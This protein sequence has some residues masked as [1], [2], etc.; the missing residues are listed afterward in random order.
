MTEN[1]ECVPT[2]FEIPQPQSD[3]DKW[4]GSRIKKTEANNRNTKTMHRDESQNFLRVDIPLSIYKKKNN[5]F[6]YIY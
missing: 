3:E 4:D 2:S 1:V 5:V 6:F